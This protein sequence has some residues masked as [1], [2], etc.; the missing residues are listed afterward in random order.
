MQRRALC[1]LLV[2]AFALAACGGGQYGFSNTST[3]MPAALTSSSAQTVTTN[4][5]VPIQLGVFIPCADGGSGEVVVLSGNLHILAT[6]TITA[7]NLHVVDVFNPQGITGVG[8]VT[9]ETYHGTGV[10]RDDA[11]VANPSFPLTLAFVNNFRI[12]GQRTGNNFLIHENSHLTINANDLVT[13]TSNQISIQ[14]K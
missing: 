6:T 10:T 7:N 4:I 8:S 3:K 14:C 5:K 11:N 1:I 2:Y 13:V 12:I 9:G